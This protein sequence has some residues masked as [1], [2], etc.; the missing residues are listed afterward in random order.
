MKPDKE[1]EE[2]L[3]YFIEDWHWNKKSHE[4]ARRMALFMFGFFEYLKSQKLSESTQ[5]K[6]ES[7]SELIG[8]FVA[9][10]GYYNEFRLEILAGQP[11]YINQFKRKVSNSHYMVQSYK[12]TWRKLAKYAKSQIKQNA[13]TPEGDRAKQYCLHKCSQIRIKP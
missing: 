1:F 12:T 10:Y 6:H 7:N 2:D 8:K 3:E 4:F 9:D 11:D 13:Q 5:R